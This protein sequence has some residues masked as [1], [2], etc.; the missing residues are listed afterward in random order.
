MPV[1]TS[2]LAAIDLNNCQPQT[3]EIEAAVVY[4]CLSR[5]ST[6]RL[7]PTYFRTRYL[8]RFPESKSN[9]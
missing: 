4:S 8:V 2:S 6:P 5:S 7:L 1:H 9:I 3:L